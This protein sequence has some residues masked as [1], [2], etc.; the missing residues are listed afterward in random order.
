MYPKGS[1]RL[2]LGAIS[3]SVAWIGS[4]GRVS[5][6]GGW[7]SGRM[8]CV[9][10]GVLPPCVDCVRFTGNV[11]VGSQSGGGCGGGSGGGCAVGGF[12]VCDVGS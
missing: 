2:F 11:V 6:G 10:F 3:P 4:E 5:F 9:R 12:G 8:G 1:R 7:L